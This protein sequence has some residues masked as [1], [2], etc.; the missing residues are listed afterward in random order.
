M[1]SQ[2]PA[3]Q[4]L[5]TVNDEDLMR[6][7]FH[8]AMKQLKD[9]NKWTEVEDSH[10]SN[11]APDDSPLFFR[12]SSTQRYYCPDPGRATSERLNIFRNVGRVLGLSLLHN[13]LCPIP[14]SRPVVKQVHKL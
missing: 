11:A 2:L 7:R 12:P 14:L 10:T 1:L 5:M 6:I 13:E 9:A 4:L 3:N 8:D